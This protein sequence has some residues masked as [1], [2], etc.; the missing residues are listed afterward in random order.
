LHPSRRIIGSKGKV[1]SGR[2]IVLAVCGSVAAFKAPELAREIMKQ[3]AEVIPVMSRGALEFI[4][5]GTMHW[6][7][8]NE[9]IAEITGRT[10]HVELCGN[11]EGRADALVIAPATANVISEIAQGIDRG[12]VSILASAALG[13]MM[14]LLIVPAMHESL[15]KNPILRSNIERLERAGAKIVKPRREGEKAKLIEADELVDHVAREICGEERMKGKRIVVAAGATREYID[16]VRF[17]S[18]R[19][20]GKMGVEIAREAWRRGGEVI[21]VGA[22]LM[23]RVPSYIGL[24]ECETAEEMEEALLN[25]RA[26][27]YVFAAAVGDFEVEKEEGKLGAGRERK[28]VL[29]PRIKLVERVRKKFANA[30]FVIFKAEVDQKVLKRNARKRREEIGAE[31]VVAN[32]VGKQRG[33][34]RAD[35]KATII[36][37]KREEEVFGKEEA[38]RRIVQLII[39]GK[40]TVSRSSEASGHP[41]RAEEI[42]R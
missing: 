6:A 1:L 14:P 41:V 23:E 11:V 34:G 30:R 35:Y 31:Y 28:L 7:T 13:N 40:N 26:D 8:G 16:D 18:N 32:I 19:S 3:G 12:P 17:I 33:F 38:A 10:E 15:Y 29:R 24:V 4:G 25:E 22:N 36:G 9:V 39:G 20:T 2:K 42:H 37:G 5:K 27:A 21:L